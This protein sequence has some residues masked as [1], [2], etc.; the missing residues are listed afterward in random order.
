[1][2]R[3]K[4]LMENSQFST[5]FISKEEYQAARAWGL[6]ASI[7]LY[8]CSKEKITNPEYIKQFVAD[9][10][11]EIDMKAFGPTH[12]EKFAEG[13]M[14]GFSAFQFIETS[15][16]T[17]HFDDKMGDKSTGDRAFI[18]IF[19]CKHFDAGKARDFAA[20][21]FDAKST[22]VWNLHRA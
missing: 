12:V 20:K 9:L 1:M 22:K 2:R 13:D 3:L 5:S 6:L 8:G 21:A 10:C 11:K 16:I 17:I 19:S 7:N 18:D 4:R 14:E 15:S